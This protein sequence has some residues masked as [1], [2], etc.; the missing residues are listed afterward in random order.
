MAPAFKMQKHAARVLMAGSLLSFFSGPAILIYPFGIFAIAI[1]ESA[2]LPK[3]QIAATIGPVLLLTIPLAPVLGWIIQRFH[4]PALAVMGMVGAGCGLLVL[5]AAPVTPIL[6]TA[7]LAVA[8]LLT[9]LASPGV[10]SALVTHKFD[11][12][13]GLALGAVSAFTGLG[14]A[15]VPAVDS[16]MIGQWSWRHAYAAGGVVI[17]LAAVVNLLLLRG[18][19][20]TRSTGGGVPGQ[21][22]GAVLKES[23]AFLRRDPTF[24]LIAGYFFLLVVVA[25]AMPLHL[26]LILEERG[27][28][29]NTQALSLTVTGVTMV[30]ARPLLG[31]V[32][33]WLS[34]RAVLAILATG[35]LVGVLILLASGGTSLAL[36][37]AACFGLALGGEIVC[38]SY[39]ISRAFPLERFGSTYGWCMLVL[40]LAAGAGPIAIS[41]LFKVGNSYDAPLM[42]MA[43]ASL[44]ALILCYFLKESRIRPTAVGLVQQGA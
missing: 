38:L 36:V 17:L 3:Q 20:S 8:F 40:A 29:A 18:V 39:I 9:Q 1:A 41:A 13:R 42:M 21:A 32:L 26:P 31:W 24:W 44:L 5:S 19:S 30:V 22:M 11:K 12:G 28:A 10:T 6:F 15:V 34:V 33:D 25:N 43:V 23:V 4:T 16:W 27:A 14:V 2:G 7:F 35:P 37:S